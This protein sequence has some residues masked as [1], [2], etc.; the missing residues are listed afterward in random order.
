MIMW[1][2]IIRIIIWPLALVILALL[3][4]KPI[5]ERIRAM[6]GFE[7]LENKDGKK[8]VRVSFI[9][10]SLRESR[11]ILEIPENSLKELPHQD[12]PKQA[13]MYAWADLEKCAQEK[14]DELGIDYKQSGFKNTALVYLELRG[15]FPP[16]TETAIQNLQMLRNQIAHYPSEAISDIDANEYIGIKDEIKKT[17]DAIQGV[18]AVQLKSI[19]MI[20]RN[21]SSVID[22]GAYNHITISE[23]HEHIENETILN[24]IAEMDGAQE[25]KGILDSDL[26]KGFDRFYTKSL[27]SIYYG[28]AGKERS[29]WGIENSGLCLIMAWT[30]EIIQMGSGWHPNENLSE[31]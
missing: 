9:E 10:T 7:Y 27:K 1:A 31:L 23:I 22:D 2:E 24:F 28:Y 3:F 16:K 11:E 29:K 5:Q 19:S 4:R 14:V 20:M 12:D 15:C 26:W 6:K 30:V 18:P 8:R 21:L 17:I 25:L 13:I